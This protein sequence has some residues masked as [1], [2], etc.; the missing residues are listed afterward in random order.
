MRQLNGMLGDQ[1]VYQIILDKRFNSFA[2]YNL[3]ILY[4]ALMICNNKKNNGKTQDL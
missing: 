2:L 3:K 4:K 1:I